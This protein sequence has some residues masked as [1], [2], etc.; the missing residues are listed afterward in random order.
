MQWSETNQK[1]STRADRSND[2]SNRRRATYLVKQ[3][4]ASRVV[5][6]L[7]SSGIHPPSAEVSEALVNKHPHEIPPEEQ[8]YDLE[9][10][11]NP[12]ADLPS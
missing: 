2:S 1:E 6:A 7:N 8:E 9:P 4:Q 12:P 3:N 10:T 5:H 11:P